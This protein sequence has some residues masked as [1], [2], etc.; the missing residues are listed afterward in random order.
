MERHALFPDYRGYLIRSSNREAVGF[1]YGTRSEPGQWWH[2]QV[3]PRLTDR[4]ALRDCWV[5]TELA[6]VPAHQGHG[7]GA[8]LHDAIL[9]GLPYQRAALSTQVSNAR[10]RRF[11]ERRGWRNL[12]AS[13]AFSP[14][15]EP[16]TIFGK[17]LREERST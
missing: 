13:M 6:V 14:G 8:W 2:D 5:L 10:A 7:L 15:G 17:E 16:F 4:G 9:A 1:I 11:Y 3:L 12:V